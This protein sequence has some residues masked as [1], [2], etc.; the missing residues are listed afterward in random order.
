MNQNGLAG[1]V[2]KWVDKL[3]TGRL[4]S[5]PPSVAVADAY[6]TVKNWPRLKHWTRTGTWGHAEY[7]RLA[8]GAIAERHFRSRS[9]SRTNS[10]F[11]TIW[12]SADGLSLSRPERELTPPLLATQRQLANHPDHLGILV[13]PNATT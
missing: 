3:P 5:P 10:E 13:D 11:E 6:A 7:L 4:N 12:Q 8:Y 2:V 9:G 1:D